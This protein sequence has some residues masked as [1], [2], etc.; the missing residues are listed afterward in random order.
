MEDPDFMPGRLAVVSQSGAISSYF[1][2]DAQRL[3]I[4]FSYW[5]ATGNEASVETSSVVKYLISD[6]CHSNKIVAEM[7]QNMFC[8]MF[9]TLPII[10]I[11][12]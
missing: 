7:S 11:R 4:G 9:L 5:V 2:K 1:M 3:K 10:E 6:I 8:N 12:F